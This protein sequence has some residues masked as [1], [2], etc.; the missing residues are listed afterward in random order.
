MPTVSPQRMD[1]VTQA[2]IVGEAYIRALGLHVTVT[3]AT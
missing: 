2:Q 3:Q 1:D